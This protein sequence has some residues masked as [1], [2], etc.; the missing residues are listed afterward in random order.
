MSRPSAYFQ[1]RSYEAQAFL[2]FSAR[3]QTQTPAQVLIGKL[4]RLIFLI[5]Y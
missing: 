4:Y 1:V 3:L 2:A 5:S